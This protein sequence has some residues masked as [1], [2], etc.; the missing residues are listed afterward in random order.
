[1]YSKKV[2]ERFSNPKF[3][4]EIENADAM[5]E[6]GNM[7]CGDFMRI[8]IKVKDNTITDIKFK[9]YGCVA[10]VAASD[11]I[12]EM[13]KGKKLEEAMKIT[14]KEVLKEFGEMPVQKYHCSFMGIKA[15]QKAINNYK[16][17][18]VEGVKD[19]A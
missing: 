17:K 10:A 2:L 9:T 7:K 8:Y 1:M 14:G 18:K 4:G 16:E 13:V 19:L 5:G 15:L 12:C 11:M 6:E 3:G